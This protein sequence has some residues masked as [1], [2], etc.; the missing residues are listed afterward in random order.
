MSSTSIP[1]V[2]PAPAITPIQMTSLLSPTVDSAEALCNFGERELICKQLYE[3]L[4]QWQQSLHRH[5]TL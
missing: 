2:P 1:V 5:S 3:E 4:K